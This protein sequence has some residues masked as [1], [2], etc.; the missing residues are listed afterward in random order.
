MSDHKR[1]QLSV[2][3]DYTAVVGPGY[4]NLLISTAPGYLSPGP[5]ERLTEVLLRN[6]PEPIT[7]S[8]R[9]M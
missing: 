2:M 4:F 9:L 6:F 7:A 1:L 5:I 8:W 3:T